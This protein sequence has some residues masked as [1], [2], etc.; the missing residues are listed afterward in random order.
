MQGEFENVQ[1]VAVQLFAHVS[2]KR[3]GAKRC[4]EAVGHVTG[5]AHGV[6]SGEGTLGNTQHMELHRPGVGFLVAVDAIQ[7]SQL[8]GASGR[9]R[10]CPSVWI[11][12]DAVSLNKTSKQRPPDVNEQRPKHHKNTTK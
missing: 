5:N 2:Q 6:L 1:V 12:V 3:L 8:G 4:R 7:V 11:S 10:V 9:E